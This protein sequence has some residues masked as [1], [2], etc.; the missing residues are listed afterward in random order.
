MLESATEN[1]Y[2]VHRIPTGHLSVAGPPYPDSLKS[3]QMLH[4]TYV[5]GAGAI[6]SRKRVSVSLLNPSQPPREIPGRA[7]TVIVC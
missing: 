7:K 3:L 1:L 6:I 2:E 5:T 4:V